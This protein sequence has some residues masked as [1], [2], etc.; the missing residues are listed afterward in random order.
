MGTVKAGGVMVKRLREND[1]LR[2]AIQDFAATVEAGAILCL[3]GSLSCA[4]LRPAGKM[5]ALVLEMP[6]EIVAATGTLGTGG[7]HVHIA[8]SDETGTTYGGHLLPGSIVRTTA[9]IVIADLSAN[10]RF[11]RHLDATTGYP[12][13]MPI[14]K[15]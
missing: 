8:V 12:E 1:D 2:A 13:L 7:I 3:V 4:R 11:E 10:W 14:P 6:L 5:E 15:G 9:E